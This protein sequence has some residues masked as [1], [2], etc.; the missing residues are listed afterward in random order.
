MPDK[1]W[2]QVLWRNPEEVIQ[3]L[4]ISNVESSVDLCCGDGY[5]T[6]PLCKLS[7][8]C[9]GIELDSS[10][11][12]EA[13]RFGLENGIN[14]CHWIN[15]DAMDIVNL[16]PELVDLVF[17]ANTYH[18]IADKE[19][20]S[21]KV[22]DVLNPN[23]SFVI[24]NWHKIPREESMVLDLPRGPK[25]EVRTSP[26]EVIDVVSKAGFESKAI[27]ELPPYHYAVIFK[28]I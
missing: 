16:V 6:V 10:L 28:K 23:G 4:G 19:M 1:D 20:L 18:G 27:I 26:S 15:G 22:A 24:V 3:Q 11:V 25:F 2:W 21:A 17:I 7:K 12:Q 8:R 9:Y 13:Q 14:N 5:F